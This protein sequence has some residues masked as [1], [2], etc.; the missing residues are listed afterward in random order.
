MAKKMTRSKVKKDKT[1]K[2]DEIYYEEFIRGI[3]EIFNKYQ[4]NDYV[5][6]D[7]HTEMYIGK[8]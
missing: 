8:I 3:I 4:E 1:P 5:I 6:F 2:E 7:F